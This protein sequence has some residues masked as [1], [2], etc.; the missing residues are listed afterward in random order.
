[1][2]MQARKLLTVLLLGT[3]VTA[4]ASS[5]E[6]QLPMKLDYAEGVIMRSDNAKRIENSG[7]QE[8][9]AQLQQARDKYREA[10]VAQQNRQFKESEELANQALRMV[11]TAAQMVPNKNQDDSQQKRRYQELLHQV[12]TYT[13]WH[14]NSSAVEQSVDNEEKQKVDEQLR[15]AHGLAQRG[16]YAQANELLNNVLGIVVMKTNSSLK[17]K[18]FTYDLN[19]ETAIDEYNYELSRNDDYQRLIPIAITQKQPSAGIRSLMDRFVEKAT[20]LRHDAEAQFEQKQYE[21]AVKT[22][23]SSTD[24]LLRALKIAGVR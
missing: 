2:M 16:N 8:A 9:I 10:R 14:S 19:F 11:T 24:E 3:A 13:S 5:L 22:M 23:Q 17:S 6:M 18:T 15:K 4:A 12:E 20:I 1:M 7:N 21:Q